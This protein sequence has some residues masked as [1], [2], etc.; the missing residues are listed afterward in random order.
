MTETPNELLE[1]KSVFE[2]IDDAK[3][4]N[5]NYLV[6]IVS[7]ELADVPEE[8]GVFYLKNGKLENL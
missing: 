8:V 6:S 7:K 2:L 3:A 4:N 1:P 5:R